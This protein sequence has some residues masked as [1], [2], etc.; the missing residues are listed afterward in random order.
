MGGRVIA[1]LAGKTFGRLTVLSRAPNN[2]H[3]QPLWLCRCECGSEKIAA[4]GSLVRGS[5]KSCGCLA[6][7]KA[8]QLHRAVMTHGLSKTNEYHIWVGMKSRCYVP[9]TDNCKNYGAKGVKVCDRWRNSFPN[10]LADVGP[11]PSK[12]HT[13][14]RKDSKGDYEPGNVRWATSRE[15]NNN[16]SSNRIVDYRGETLTL[17]NA[18]RK[19]G[20]VVRKNT[21]QARLEKGW[22]VEAAVE[23]RV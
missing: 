7:E 12:L 11:R 21:A 3:N 18:L 13:L 14:D 19:A 9:A 6:R 8:A 4:G 23:T 20:N 1:P 5:T 16:R 17:A 15:Q 10:F 2:V 22:T